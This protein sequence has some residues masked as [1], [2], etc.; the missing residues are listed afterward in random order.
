MKT[1]VQIAQEAKMLPISEVAAN[2]GIHDDELEL[3]GKYKAK[4]SLEVLKRLAN[5]PDAK[6]V[7][8]TAIN[9]TPAGKAR[10]RPMSAFRWGST[11]SARRPS[12]PCVNHPCALALAS[13]A[14]RLA[15]AMPRL[16]RWMISICISRVT[17][18]PSRRRI[19]CSP[20]CWTT[21]CTRGTP[22]KLTRSGLSETGRGY[23]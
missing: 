14:A 6:L 1:D 15:A 16:C 8:V 22:C 18:M 23:E 4:I 13:R 19:I 7:L 5:K 21:T 11:K 10:P 3:Y 20:H 17:S 12:Q 9:P 2:L